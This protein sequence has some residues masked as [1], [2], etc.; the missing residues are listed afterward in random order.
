MAIDPETT[1]RTP[2]DRTHRHLPP[3]RAVVSSIAVVGPGGVGIFFAA[4]LAATE[5]EVIACARRPF[6][7]YVVESS[8]A[9]ISGPA[10]VLTDPVAVEGPVDWVLVALKAQH[11]SG[12]ADWLDRLCGPDTVV[13]ALQ[14]GIEAES[15]LA[16]FVNGVPVL[17]A[18]VYC[19]GTLVAP[20]HTRNTGGGRLLLPDVDES[21]RLAELFA[22]TA[23]VIRPDPGHHTELWRK[24]GINVA[25]NGVTAL[26]DKPIAVAGGG[27]GRTVAR[28]L[29][30][31]CWTV[32]EA[33]GAE[34]LLETIEETL[35]RFATS[36]HADTSMRQDRRAGRPTEHDALYGAVVR[37]GEAQGIP[38]PVSHAIGALVAAGD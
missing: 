20:G 8:V 6:D 37:R 2:N 22:D 27:P 4:H 17:A 24:L 26:A 34:S 13:V 3:A 21:H 23:A 35:D 32:A 10:T 5:H 31:E 15:R 33:D 25:V 16:P 36:I 18:V 7:R 28:A 11:T 38:T 29:L 30:Q 1:S 12:A 14:N 19:G 9:P